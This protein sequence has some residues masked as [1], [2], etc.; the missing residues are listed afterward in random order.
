MELKNNNLF[1]SRARYLVIDPFNHTYNPAKNVFSNNKEA[2]YPQ[3][4]QLALESVLES[5]KIH[6]NK[7]ELENPEEK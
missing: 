7:K 4:F 2:L 3:V 1:A 6:L 5:G